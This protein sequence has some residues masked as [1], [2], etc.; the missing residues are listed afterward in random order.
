MADQIIL[1]WTVPVAGSS[2]GPL[3]AVAALAAIELYENE[4][5]DP[6]LGQFFGLTVADDSTTSD[7]TSAT[8]T[9]TL[10]MNAVSSPEAPPPFPCHPRTSTPPVLPYPLV[11]TKSLPGFFFVELGSAIVPTT[12]TQ[13]PSLTVG[14]EIQF[15]NQQGVVYTVLSIDSATQI[16][17]TTPFTGTTGNTGAFKE[18]AAPCPLEFC[19][20]YSSSELDTT[21]VATVPVIQPGP[22]ARE[23]SLTYMDSTGAGPFTATADLTGKRPVLFDFSESPAT[24]VAVI[25]NLVITGAGGFANSVGEITIVELSDVLPDFPPNLPIGTGIG[26]AQTTE[27][28]GGTPLP[29]TFKTMTDEAQLLIDRHLA[30]LPLSFFALAQQQRS[31]PALEG[32]FIVTTGSIDVPTTED[33]S[34]EVDV[35]DFIEFSVQPG[36]RYEVAAVTPKII[37][38]TEVFLGIDTNDTGL[39]NTPVKNA[40]GTKG[41]IGPGLIEHR[42]GARLV[43]PINAEAPSNDELSVPLGQYVAPGVA[44][45]PPNP[46]LSPATVPVPAFLSDYFT[47]TIQL[48]L[49]GVPITP[50][51]ITFA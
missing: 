7:A 29:R 30:Y 51:T 26:P 49:A 10:N 35:G 48:A 32:D 12:A 46:P 38:L 19:A 1:A 3:A 36:T 31:F 44:A 6:V 22:G 41:N 4:N 39:N 20:A 37:R 42:T 28:K 34:T 50:A 15:L 40:M 9:L 17:L 24:D 16:T 8:R 33:Q 45:P 21:G 43:D 5:T 18:V 23:V 27:G 2:L 13:L 47:Q 11:T 25:V 14:D